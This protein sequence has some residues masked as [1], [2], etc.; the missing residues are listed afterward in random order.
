MEQ[1]RLRTLASAMAMIVLLG[2]A[3]AAQTPVNPQAGSPRRGMT[4]LASEIGADT[5]VAEVLDFVDS[6]RVDFVVFDFA[7]ITG[8]WQRAKWDELR[9]VCSQLKKRNVRVAFM[10][11]PR[12]LS[13]EDARVHFARDREG[14]VAESHLHLCLAHADSQ[15]WAAQWGSRILSQIPSVDTIMI[16]NLLSV[17]QCPDCR[18]GK[19]MALA[20][21]FL[22]R[23]RTDW[24][25]VRPKVQVGHVG[26][27]DEY[28]G[29]VDFFCPFVGVNHEKGREQKPLEFPQQRFEQ[30]RAAH[31]KKWMAPLLKYCWMDATNNST[32]DIVQSLRNC[33]QNKTGFLAWYYEWILHEPDRPYDAKAIVEALGGDWSRL[34]KYYPR[35]PGGKG[36]RPR[37][38]VAKDLASLLAQFRANPDDAYADVVAAGEPAVEGVAAIMMD[39]AAA[40]R[41]RYLAANALGGI[42]SKKAMKPLLAAL[43]DQDFNVRRCAADSLSRLG[44]PSV[45]PELQRL[46]RSDP[47]F[48]KDPKTRK[49]QYF[50][51]DAAKKALRVLRQGATVAAAAD[52][53]KQ[54]E[55]FLADASKPPPC[56]PAVKIRRLPW[57]FP[58]K[59]EDMKIFNNYQQ[60]TDTYVH[61]GLDFLLPM[62]TEC[63]A[64]EDGYVA[65]IFTNYPK[66]RTH[67]FFIVATERDGNEGWCYVHLDKDTYTFKEGDRIRQGQVLAKIVDFSKEQN[68][69][70]NHHL[71]LHYV[72]FK[73]KADGTV[74]VESL[75]DPA[76]FFDW[77][78][79]SPPQIADPL[80][81]VRKGTLDEFAKDADGMATVSGKVEIIAAISD[82]AYEG[83]F[84][85]W[86][87]PVV[88]LEIEG[89][90]AKPWRKLVLDQRGPILEKDKFGAPALYLSY[91]DAAKWRRDLPPPGSVHFVKVTSSE[92]DGVV[93][94]SDQLHS[95]DTAAKDSAG[96]RRFPDGVYTV[97]VRAWD[98]K[99]NQAARTAKVRV[100]NKK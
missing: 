80:R 97:T 75:I 47:F 33:L 29:A 76:L 93:E 13:A 86:M 55:T 85:H 9:E 1:K 2:G 71:H 92:G 69:K 52:L 10:Y 39:K 18:D 72:R 81:F 90:G 77:K 84:C 50:V 7:W 95:W 78:D 46:A 65:V 45:V 94:A 44:D 56:E 82:N 19:G 4:F 40:S 87:T 88:T 26:I 25:R 36:V 41:A 49:T 32:A 74:D 100:S 23:C 24:S 83:H 61:G 15:A 42:K 43:K 11:R 21:K 57:P 64:V 27:G 54:G 34:G 35:K 17:C 6:C 28:I 48:I 8:T 68:G 30:Y 14:K 67:Y 59:M 99:E 12:A 91:N 96:K 63:R 98:L 73:K 51:R 31:A 16:Y 62:G 70:G 60:A 89:A 53:H 22:Q 66:V 79:T 5:S 20:E 38:P 37:A 58:G 3:T